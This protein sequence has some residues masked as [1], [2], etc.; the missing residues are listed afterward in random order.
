MN[1][2]LSTKQQPRP[3]DSTPNKPLHS[4]NNTNKKWIKKRKQIKAISSHLS[5]VHSLLMSRLK[6]PRMH[7]YRP[8]LPKMLSLRQ[9]RNRQKQRKKMHL[10][11]RPSLQSQQRRRM[12]HPRKKLRRRSQKMRRN[13]QISRKRKS[14]QLT[15]KL[16]S[17]M[18]KSTVENREYLAVTTTLIQWMATHTSTKSSSLLT[19]QRTST[20]QP[21]SRKHSI[22]HYAYLICSK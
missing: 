15:R 12:L 1:K 9:M 20:T 19:W 11:M 13:L 2:Q 14:H 7:L 3:P 17:K 16:R 22:H 18:T 5:Q 8:N 21:R 4:Q 6:R 10:R